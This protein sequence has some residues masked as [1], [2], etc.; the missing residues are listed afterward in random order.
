M[1]DETI[2]KAATA[3]K[4]KV[5]FLDRSRLGYFV[6]SSLAGSYVGLGIALIFAIGAPVA[7]AGTPYLKPLM[8]I[9]FGI[10]LTLVI[11]A[12]SELFTG[13]NLIMT[14]GWLT[15]RTGARDLGRVWAWSWA[16][17]LAG[18]LALA[19]LVVASGALAPAA[20]LIGD[21][22]AAK[23]TAPTLQLV[24]RGALC[25]WLVC[26]AVWMALRTAS[27]A[28]KCI[29][30][31][32][33]LYAFIACGYEHSI[34]NMS[35]LGLALLG[36]HGDAVTWAGYARN[37]GWVTAGNVAGAVLFVAGAYWLTSAQAAGR[38]AALGARRDP[39]APA[40]QAG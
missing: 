16:G 29:L 21:V 33:C 31:F 5:A 10:A 37:I 40:A 28:A 2:E 32:W 25:N 30:I 8:G 15:G 13:N 3:A 9:S 35:L 14:L 24:L 27:D 12:G 18:S 38:L 6:A 36:P 11:M 34:A 20:K 39:P 19:A 7:A 26:L 4:A 23:M 1:Y 17:N 22:A